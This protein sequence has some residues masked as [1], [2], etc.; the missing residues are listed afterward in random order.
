N[1]RSK[2]SSSGETRCSSSGTSVDRLD[3]GARR[4]QACGLAQERGLV[5]A[6][7]GE[8]VVLAAEVAV[9]GGLLVDRA[10]ELQRLAEGAGAQ[11]EV[12][13]DELLDLP[14]ADLLGAEGLDHDRDR[15]RDADR[16]GDLD[17]GALGQAGRDDVLGDVASGV[18]GRAVDL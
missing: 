15:V 7:P 14:A 6:L 5:G 10:V 8:V 1:T 12:L 16:V 2:K 3:G 4:A 11:V 13:V 9:G 18:G 17:L